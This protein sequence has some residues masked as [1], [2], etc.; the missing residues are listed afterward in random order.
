MIPARRRDDESGTTLVELTVALIIMSLVG[1]V[2]FGFLYNVI[3]TTTRV[4]SDTETEKSIA[5]ALRPLTADVRSATSIATTY[6]GTTACPAGSYPTGYTNC[7]SLTI[8]RPMAGALT[9]P[10]SVVTYGLKSDGVLRQDRTDY[11][12]V[13]GVCSVSASYTGRALLKN[14]QNGATPLF[15]YFDSLGNAIDPNASGQTTT[16]FAGTVTVRVSTSVKYRS[17]SPLLTYTSDLA[18]RNYR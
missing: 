17:N 2:L 9:C 1:L 16:A 4:T 11:K 7:L 14:V 15:K 3:N 5:F 18:M 12:L 8:Q 10:K 13:G 6:P